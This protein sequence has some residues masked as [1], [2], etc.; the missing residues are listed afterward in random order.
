VFVI[1]E[2][3]YAHPVYKNTGFRPHNEIKSKFPHDQC[4]VDSWQRFDGGVDFQK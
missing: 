2:R 1:R 3:I 4:T